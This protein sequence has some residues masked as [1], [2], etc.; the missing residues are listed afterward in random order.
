[1]DTAMFRILY[2]INDRNPDFPGEPLGRLRDRLKNT[3]NPMQGG[4]W[5]NAGRSS[6]E[7]RTG[8]RFLCRYNN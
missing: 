4:L 2:L 6:I 3:Q 5:D 7:K 8:M 1:M